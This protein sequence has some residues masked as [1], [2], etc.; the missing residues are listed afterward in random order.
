MESLRKEAEDFDRKKERYLK[1]VNTPFTVYAEFYSSYL[2]YDYMHYLL[3]D[4]DVVKCEMCMLSVHQKKNHT[5]KQLVCTNI[6][7]IASVTK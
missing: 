3:C 7:C 5:L 2:V 6:I 1:Y 4:D